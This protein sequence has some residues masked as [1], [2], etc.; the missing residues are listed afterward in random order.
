MKGGTIASNTAGSLINNAEAGGVMVN[1]GVFIMEGGTIYG[2]VNS[3]P[4]GTDPGL[5]NSAPNR[6][7][8]RLWRSTATWGTGGSYT[9]GGES[10]TSGSDISRLTYSPDGEVSGTNDTLIAIPARNDR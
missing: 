4:P 10:Q 7:S 8:L 5:A 9:I 1:E 6:A 3:L 2:N